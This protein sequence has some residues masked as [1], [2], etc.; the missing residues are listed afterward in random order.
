MKLEYEWE[1]KEERVKT[2]ES[3]CYAN[4]VFVA[5][6]ITPG[7]EHLYVTLG[8]LKKQRGDGHLYRQA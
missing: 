7:L 1:C 3:R 2:R 6:L 5:Q 8:T 4:P